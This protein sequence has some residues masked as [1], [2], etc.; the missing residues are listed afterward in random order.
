[1]TTEITLINDEVVFADIIGQLALHDYDD[2]VTV[3]FVSHVKSGTLLA[4]FSDYDDAKDF[5][6]KAC[7]IMDFDRYT[8][9][10]AAAGI[11][12]AKV[13]NQPKLQAVKDLRDS[14]VT[15]MPE[16]M[17]GVYATRETIKARVG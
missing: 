9:L 4:A 11:Q 6:T 12:F 2:D 13:F 7:E 16:H 17:P 3:V 8:W 5:A 10:I 1:M 15:Y 14:Y